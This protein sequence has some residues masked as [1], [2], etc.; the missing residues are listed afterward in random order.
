MSTM[1]EHEH[2]GV[3]MSDESSRSIAAFASQGNFDSAQR[4]AKALASSSLV[5]K[6]YHNN[7]AN[8]LVAMELASR[9]GASVLMIMQNLHIIQGRPSWSAKFLIA[10]VNSCGHFSPL[11]YELVGTEAMAG[12]KCR[13]YA[14]DLLSDDVL[15]GEWITWEMV[16]AEGWLSKAG[17]KWKT[18]P[19]QMIRYRAASF[20]TNTYAPEISLGMSTAEESADIPPR[21]SAS[22][23]ASDLNA[24]LGTVEAKPLVS[25]DETDEERDAR[26]AEDARIAEID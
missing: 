23:G 21:G 10:S 24:A 5:P 20:W 15:H 11:R 17:S 26:L 14:T 9:T 8:C 25:G 2:T 13:A 7:I 4:M 19:G 1:I 18:M 22:V 6:E 12:W 3:V 16:N